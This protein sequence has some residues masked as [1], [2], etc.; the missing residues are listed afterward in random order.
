MQ[1]DARYIFTHPD[2]APLIDM[3]HAAIKE[4]FARSAANA[5]L[6]ANQTAHG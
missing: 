4:E 1:R 5:T 3:R 6:K 2:M